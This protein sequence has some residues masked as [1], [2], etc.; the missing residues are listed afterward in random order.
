[1]FVA[2][3]RVMLQVLKKLLAW[4]RST[5]AY[6]YN[7]GSTSI[8]AAVFSRYWQSI[9]AITDKDIEW[10]ATGE[11]F[12]QRMWDDYRQRFAGQGG[13]KILPPHSSTRVA[14]VR[15]STQT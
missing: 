3:C 4:Q 1:M 5:E 13:W 2:A 15:V 9:F 10:A 12:T 6:P 8:S 7:A 14:Y 11:R